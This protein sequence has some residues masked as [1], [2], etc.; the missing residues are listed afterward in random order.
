MGSL[1]VTKKGHQFIMV[2]TNHFTKFIKVCAL[3]SL[4]KQKVT[5]F[6]YEQFFTQFGTPLKIVSD[7]GR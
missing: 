7:N 4:V 6:L 2:T 5:Q 3:K 1:L